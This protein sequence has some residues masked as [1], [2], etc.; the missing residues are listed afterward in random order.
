MAQLVDKGILSDTDAEEIVLRYHLPLRALSLPIPQLPAHTAAQSE[1]ED[2]AGR[3]S[4]VR[5]SSR[6]RWRRS[7]SRRAGNAPVQIPHI[8]L[9]QRN[10]LRERCSVMIDCLL[11]GDLM[12]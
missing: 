5:P 12:L 8:G 4:A 1:P 6:A 10:P 11:R 3:R 9:G 7:P 2:V